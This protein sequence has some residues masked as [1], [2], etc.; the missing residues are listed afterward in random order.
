DD[1]NE[2]ISDTVRGILDGHILLSRDLAD[3]NHFPAI[4][5][6]A[7][8]SRVMKDI[9]SEDHMALA[10]KLKQLIATYKESEPLINIGAYIKG[11]NPIIDESIKKMTGINTFLKQ[12]IQEKSS[13]EE[14]LNFL[15]KTVE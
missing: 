7:S 2:P 4:D 10:G 15:K 11:S 5:I 12:G 9:S 1:D 6:T 8:I 13:L 14:T 3:K